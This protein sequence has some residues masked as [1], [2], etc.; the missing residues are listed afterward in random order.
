MPKRGM[1][2]YFF[3][4][5]EQIPMIKKDQG[6]THKAAMSESGRLWR[7]MSDAEKKPYNEMAAEDALR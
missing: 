5:N 7:E 4:G 1:N 3:F 6:L 2:A